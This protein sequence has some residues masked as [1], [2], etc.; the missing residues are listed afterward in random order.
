MADSQ[1][2]ERDGI[3]FEA[4]YDGRFWNVTGDGKRLYS[5]SES[6]RWKLQPYIDK[7]WKDVSKRLNH[8]PP[9]M[10]PPKRGKIRGYAGTNEIPPGFRIF[11]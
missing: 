6:A 1:V 8:K 9:E 4:V 7:N 5:L 10:K 3:T 2:Y 11:H